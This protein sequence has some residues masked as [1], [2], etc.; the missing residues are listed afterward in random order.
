MTREQ[1]TAI[2]LDPDGVFRLDPEVVSA[3]F[4]DQVVL[5]HLGD[6]RT[7]TLNQAAGLI[8]ELIDS[9]CSA[10]EIREVLQRAFPE[11]A[12]D[13]GHDVDHTLRYLLRH[14]ALESVMGKPEAERA[15]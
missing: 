2:D 8:L 9:R 7:L 1:G 10:A 5:Y 14:G 6:G 15:T 12:G 4:D 13:V 11:S 3:T